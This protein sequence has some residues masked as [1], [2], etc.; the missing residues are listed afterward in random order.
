MTAAL[1]AHAR[2]GE[3]RRCHRESSHFG[4]HRAVRGRHLGT[5]GA[6]PARGGTRRRGRRCRLLRRITTAWSARAAAY[7]QST[8]LAPQM[9][10]CISNQLSPW[11][12]FVWKP[13]AMPTTTRNLPGGS[14]LGRKTPHQR[15]TG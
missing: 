3:A 7:R 9:M 8:R 4:V 10:E 1:A 13:A 5:R 6:G 2:Y 12:E 11:F 14:E 15:S